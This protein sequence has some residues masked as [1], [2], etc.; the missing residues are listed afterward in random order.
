MMTMMMTLTFPKLQTSNGDPD[1]NCPLTGAHNKAKVM[2]LF[3]IL[4]DPTF[5]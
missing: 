2:S 4:I 3:Y 5:L 1:P